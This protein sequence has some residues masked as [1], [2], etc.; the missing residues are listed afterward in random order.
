MGGISPIFCGGCAEPSISS[1]A[2]WD[3]AGAVQILVH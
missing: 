2:A 1:Q 3:Y